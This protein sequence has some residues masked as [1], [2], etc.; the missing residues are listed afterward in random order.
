MYYDV[1]RG[2]GVADRL[3]KKMDQPCTV[4]V[5]IKSEVDPGWNAALRLP[6]NKNIE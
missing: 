3:W 4:L 6:E 5:W 2:T 1:S